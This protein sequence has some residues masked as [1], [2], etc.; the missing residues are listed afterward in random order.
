MQTVSIEIGYRPSEPGVRQSL[1]VQIAG[2]GDGHRVTIDSD[3]NEVGVLFRLAAVLYARGWNVMSARIDSPGA[4]RIRDEFWILP[5]GPDGTGRIEEIPGD[6]E[7][8]LFQGV[9]VLAYLTELKSAPPAE[10]MQQGC[11]YAAPSDDGPVIVMSGR[12]QRGVLLKVTQAFFLM[13]IN[14]V[15]AQIDTLPNGE[16]R[17]TFFVDPLD[18]RFGAHDFRVQ[19]AQE[20]SGLL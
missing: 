15:R 14:I 19:L 13:D 20:L 10:S 3:V 4:S 11:V 8:L 2:W 18:R 17:N 1:S 16:V 12:D 6:L 5:A 9:S 7:R